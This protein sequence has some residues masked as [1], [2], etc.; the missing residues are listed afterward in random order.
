MFGIPGLNNEGM[1]FLGAGGANPATA[2][3]LTA[4]FGD[5]Y[6]SYKNYQLSKEQYRYQKDLQNLMME[7]EDNSVQRRVADLQKAG[8]SP[9]LAAG[10]GAS[11]GPVVSTTTP[12][13]DFNFG[14][15]A[16]L[17]MSLLKMQADISKTQ[18]EKEYIDL[19]KSKIPSEIQN[20]QSQAF[21]N[22]Q[23]GRQEKVSADTVTKTGVPGDSIVGKVVNDIMGSA[24]TAEK[25]V[26]NIINGAKKSIEQKV[27]PKTNRSNVSPN[28]GYKPEKVPQNGIDSKYNMWEYGY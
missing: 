24:Y 23:K 7:R 8:L 28:N 13:G 4:T 22:Y 5:A 2:L 21:S 18:A 11:S 14:E 12:H 9:V 3:G 26:N 27:Q 19:Q 10:T 25:G 6:M 15:S 16:G 1:V 17:A 20:L